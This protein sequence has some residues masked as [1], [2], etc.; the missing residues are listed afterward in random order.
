[1]KVELN[2]N[3]TVDS[4]ESEALQM[5]VPSCEVAIDVGQVL[6][7]NQ[8]LLKRMAHKMETLEAKLCNMELT[9]AK[10][11][12]M[13]AHMNNQ[14]TFLLAPPEKEYKPWQPRTPQLD[15]DY[16]GKFSW[17]DRLFRPWKMRRQ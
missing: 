11:T 5:H 6:A 14:T 2:V 7:A 4:N 9:Y 13:L 10:Q 3:E 17:A 16:F 12:A 15:S 1:M 8:A